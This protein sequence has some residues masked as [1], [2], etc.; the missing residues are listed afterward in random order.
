MLNTKGFGPNQRIL[1]VS[2]CLLLIALLGYANF[3]RLSN[4][5]RSQSTTPALYDPLTSDETAQ[6]ASVV[7]YL[8]NVD[9]ETQDNATAA[10]APPREVLL[11]TQR[12]DG[13]KVAAGQAA[14]PRQSES[15]IY[16]YDRDILRHIIVDLAT[17]EVASVEEV[18]D[19]QLPLTQGE[20]EQALDLVFNDEVASQAIFEQY[21]AATGTSLGSLD[22]LQQK[23]FIFKADT[24][25]NRI[26]EAAQACGIQRCAQVLLFTQEKVAFEITPIVNI[27]QGEIAQILWLEE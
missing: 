14:P 9:T 7:E 5:A 3:H 13:G 12:F 15:F 21:R 26:N 17:G 2:T 11:L 23:V 18:Q 10:E 25:P 27:S 22:E 16:D 20:I 6:T 19:V 1:I 4:P 8:L 24:M